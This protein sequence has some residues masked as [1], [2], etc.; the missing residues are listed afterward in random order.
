MCGTEFKND[1]QSVAEDDALL[2]KSA[3]RL[4]TE[5]TLLERF[6]A[7]PSPRNRIP[8]QTIAIVLAAIFAISYGVFRISSKPDVYAPGHAID[9]TSIL[10]R[11]LF[12]QHI[13]DSLQAE[14]AAHPEDTELHFSLGDALYQDGN[15]SES[16]KELGIYLSEKPQDADAR[17]DLAY[18]LAQDGN[19]PVA[20][21]EIDTGLHYQPD[22][23]DVLINAGILTTE[24][25]TDSNHAEALAKAKKYFLRAKAIAD[26]SSPAIAG[27]IDTLIQEIDK[28]GERMTK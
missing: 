8:W 10:Q 27:R 13:I 28:T 2:Q 23:L 12:M 15:W 21:S 17:V 22:N 7:T 1:P 6:K 3:N 18:A 24:S 19:M 26:T 16:Q 20:L 4:S 9:S 25:I 11:R 5:E 14:L